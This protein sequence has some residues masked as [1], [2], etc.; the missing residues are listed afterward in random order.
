M[1]ERVPSP[2]PLDGGEPRV[3][4]LDEARPLGRGARRALERFQPS[5]PRR[6]QIE[7]PA[8]PGE[9][10]GAVLELVAGDLHQLL[11]ER[12][13]GI[14][15]LGVAD[16]DL[17]E[18]RKASPL[19]VL[20]V[21]RH[22]RGGGARV[23][24]PHREDALVGPEG[25]LRNAQLAGVDGRAAKAEIDLEL[26]IGGLVG[27]AGEDLDQALPVLVLGVEGGQAVV[28]A[29]G[30]VAVAQHAQRLGVGGLDGQHALPRVHGLAGIAQS[31]GVDAAELLQDAEPGG[32]V[33]RHRRAALQHVG[34]GGEVLVA[35][36][37][38]LQGVER[39]RRGGL[40]VEYPLVE[41][42]RL[43][44][45][46]QA[47]G[48]QPGH[49]RPEIAARGAGRRG[50]CLLRQQIEERAVGA[51]LDVELLQAVDGLAVARVDDVELFV[52][53][54]GVLHVGKLL[55]PAAGD[56]AM[57]LGLHGGLRLELGL[58][59]LHRQQ[60]PPALK[61][62]VDAHQ[63]AHA[64]QIVGIELHDL[65][66]HRHQCRVALHLLAVDTSDVA[67]DAPGA[68]RGRPA[69]ADR[70]LAAADR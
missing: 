52:G 3:D 45:Q 19:L 66:E 44:P 16:Q 13:L 28:V 49:L 27:G 58:S 34:H 26:R 20:L 35:L 29:D 4:S 61:R 51:A 56:G 67:Q 2:R 46:V 38:L 62:L 63:L 69:A 25:P 55:Q 30:Q 39:A 36:G 54:D 47:L 31:I 32:V 64:R 11:Q 60:V 7:G 33:R 65:R 9:G 70:A 41:G 40:L 57:K 42:H 37:L 12:E 5:R 53:L 10:R 15:V 22:Q 18:G 43:R 23:V 8:R 48:R 50:V 59:D 1:P 68:R 21:E 17:V 14:D 24:R 6:R